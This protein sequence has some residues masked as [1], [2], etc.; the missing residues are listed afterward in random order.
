[1][2]SMVESASRKKTPNEI[3]LEILLVA[4]TIIFLLVAASLFTFSGFSATQA[5]IANPDDDHLARGAVRVPCADHHRRLALGHR[6][7]RA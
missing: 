7:C 2:I 3:A 1:M 5:D 4:L 6:H